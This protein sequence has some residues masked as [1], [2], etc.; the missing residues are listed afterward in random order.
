ML[1]LKLSCPNSKSSQ[2]FFIGKIRINQQFKF[3]MLVLLEFI[4]AFLI[5]SVRDH[6]P[7]LM[8]GMCKCSCC[9]YRNFWTF[10]RTADYPQRSIFVVRGKNVQQITRIG[11][12]PAP[13]NQRKSCYCIMAIRTHKLGAMNI[14][15]V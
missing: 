12:L 13:Q 2:T 11:L 14:P 5:H 9:T 8:L 7:A 1:K 6:E 10:T 3:N 4:N 15:W